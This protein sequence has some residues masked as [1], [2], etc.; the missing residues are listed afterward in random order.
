MNFI[1]QTHRQLWFVV[2]MSLFPVTLF[3]QIQGSVRD[4]LNQPVSF[5]NVLL[6]NQKDSSVVSGV[7]ATEEGTYSFTSFKPGTY[8]IGVSLIGY[9]SAFS[10]PFTIKTSNDHFHNEPVFVEEDSHQLQDVNV[11]VK[12][13]I[14]ELK[15]DRMVVNVENSI[16]SAGSTA[17]EVL[18][19]SPGVIVNRQNNSIS[20][21][22]KGG[23]MVMIDGKQNRMPVEAAVQMLGSMNADNV[24]R[25][26]IITTPPAKYDA[27]GDAGIINIVLK[28]NE[29][30]GT[31]GSF[32]LGAGLATREKMNGSLNLNH[33]V[34]K[35]NFFGSYSADFDNM[36]QSTETIRRLI[37]SGSVIESEAINNR[38]ALLLFQNVRMGFDYTIS[39]KTI[40][41]FLGA[42]YVRDW[43]MDALTAILYMQDQE[44]TNRT[45]LTTFELNKWIHGMGN[46]NLQHHFQEEEILDF[47]FDYL[48]YYNDNPSNY[49]VENLDNSNQPE[50]GENIEVEKITPI[51]IFVGALDYSN[52]LNPKIKIEAG[53]KGTLTNFKN[54]VGV[55]YFTSGSWDY[56]PELTN[57]Y[58]L[59][60]NI[61]A[62]YSTISFTMNDKTSIVAGLRYEYMN[63]VLDSET[64]K[65]I[66]DLHYGE[67]FPTFYF[68][69]KLNDN[70]TF[71]FAYSRRIDRPTFNQLAPFI[72]FITP[73]TF[74]SGNENLLPAFSNILK[75][76]YQYKSLMLSFSF[77]D[78]KDAI[79]GFQPRQSDDE[80]RQYLVS[81]NLDNAQTMS[82]MLAL[83]VTVTK[84]WKMQNNFNW[85]R[86]KLVTDY[87]AVDV[88]VS[89]ANFRI[90]SSQ[91]FSL[92]E[93][94][95]AEISGFYQSRSLMG[96]Y[97]SKPFGSLDFGFL[98]RLKN[99][100]SRFNLNV[101]DV[102]KTRIFRMEAN[103]PELNIDNRMKL[104]FESRILRL[105]FTHNFGTTAIKARTRN[106]ASEE[107]RRRITN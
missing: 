84:W 38:E 94:I 99:G 51:N 63:S 64:E 8:M 17:L 81:R 54:D 56:D 41:S 21:S 23:A 67:F 37:Q 87:D 85:V 66:L 76:D 75:A 28:K 19:K 53:I 35:V 86:Q 88:D 46:I 89:L 74:L 95:S 93:H 33:H 96:I 44:T 15:I 47:N 24:K 12:K 102:L 39:S 29:A 11:V 98:W 16:T 101:S 5:A 6:L 77:T 27:E 82:V 30:F 90:N 70:N 105:T 25:I 57:N 14:Y 18:E 34:E 22:G 50:S 32:S 48:N 26:E 20:I 55:R 72:I 68:S 1:F 69:Q 36:R 58:S 31:N 103:V 92:S 3:A 62:A 80:T 52:Q 9:K 78:T 100:N 40:L 10:S 107:E 83:P 106:T 65:G 42:G 43:E 13:P 45:N 91:S 73:E 61:S 59:N 104:D 79:A 60:E 2:F 49:T 4:S 7:M 97:E 71:Q